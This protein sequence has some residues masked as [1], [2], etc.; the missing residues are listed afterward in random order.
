MNSKFIKQLIKCSKSDLGASRVLYDSKKYSQS[1]YFFQ[2]S[3]E[4]LNKALGLI[5]NKITESELKRAISHFP[6]K[7]HEK[8]V[9]EQLVS[10]KGFIT[11]TKE[12]PSLNQLTKHVHVE[13]L[14]NESVR[15]LKLS[16][17]TR[18]TPEMYIDLSEVEIEYYLNQIKIISDDLEIYNPEDCKQNLTKTNIH[19]LKKKMIEAFSSFYDRYPELKKEIEDT[20]DEIA[21]DEMLSKIEAYFNSIIDAVKIIYRPY[22]VCMILSFLTTPHVHTRY[23]S[24][25]CSFIPDK[26]YTQNLPFIK[27]FPEMYDYQ[28]QGIQEIMKSLDFFSKLKKQSKKL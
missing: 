22:M 15:F 4:K 21:T 20:F 26:V 25:D 24:E 14:N 11:L 6:I 2:Q 13:N 1:V 19:E 17:E 5:S 10:T 8:I 16:Q 9:E 18:K 23:P 3:V 27:K 28:E 12:Y 7:I